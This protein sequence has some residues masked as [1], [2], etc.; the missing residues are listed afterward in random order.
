MKF[1]KLRKYRRIFY[2]LGAIAFVVIFVV[3][4]ANYKNTLCSDITVNV[5]DSA[6]SRYVTKSTVINYI[7]N[8]SEVDIIG[9]QFRNINLAEI[10]NK[11]NENYFIKNAE[12]FRSRNGIIEVKI[13]QRKPIARIYNSEGENFY[14][15]EDGYFLPTSKNYASY[16]PIF[17]GNINKIDSLYNSSL[18]NV[19]EFDS[20]IYKEIYDL[21]II[22][23]KNEFS[24]SMIDQI[25]VNETNEFEMIPK[26]GDFKIMFGTIE[27]SEIKLR[28]LKAFYT[29][30]APKVGWDKYSV[31]N[32][33]YIN[34]IV[35]EK[36][37]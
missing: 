23:R 26:V 28:N 10:E 18:K 8:N 34:Q 24:K 19:A 30:A 11:L 21:A 29:D 31:I 7:Y 22:L 1:R 37:N 17:N 16:V 32:L 25:F 33:K 27:N 20:T 15:D 4:Q 12:V 9:N 6:E 36:K 35:C 2:M 14:I 13:I 3:L 5:L